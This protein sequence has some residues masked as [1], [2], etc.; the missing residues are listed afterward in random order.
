MKV[1]SDGSPHASVV[2]GDDGCLLDV[3]QAPDNALYFSDT[4]TIHRVG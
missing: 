1:L 3:K 4:E 2:E